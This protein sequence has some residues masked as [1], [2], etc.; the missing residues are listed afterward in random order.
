MCEMACS[1]EKEGECGRIYSRIKVIK[2]ENGTDV[3]IV[4]LQCEDA[5]CENVCPAHAISKNTN[6]IIV[7]DHKLCIGCKVCLSLC[8]VGA[9]SLD[10]K[11]KVIK[12]DLCSG[13]PKCVTFCQP[14][15]L[16][17]TRK[18]KVDTTKRRS[19]AEKIYLYEHRRRLVR[20]KLKV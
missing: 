11:C 14:K 20:E 12:C 17:F 7:I 10:P 9:I 8:P 5:M 1:L 4:C 15:A 16:T 6:G 18:H 13:E 19:L 3:P 2:M